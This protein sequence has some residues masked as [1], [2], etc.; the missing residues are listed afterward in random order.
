MISGDTLSA[1][2]GLQASKQIL[3]RPV[4]AA[5]EVVSPGPRGTLL[6]SPLSAAAPFPPN[7]VLQAEGRAGGRASSEPG[8][9]CCGPRDERRA[10]SES[11]T[12]GR[13]GPAWPWED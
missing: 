7:S 2:P 11:T 8:P 12:A 13:R 5:P 1:N 6:P 9:P 4:R 3:A 10:F